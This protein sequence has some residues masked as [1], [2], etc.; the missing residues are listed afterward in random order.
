MRTFSLSYLQ[1]MAD[2]VRRQNL[3]AILIAPS[4]DLLFI[5][6]HNPIFCER[7]QGL[8]VKA[9]GDYFYVCNLLTKEEMEAILPNRKVYAWFDGDGFADT[10]RTALE[11]N[12]LTGKTIGVNATVRA[13][14]LLE[15]SEAVEV[16]WVSAR[17]LPQEIRI[18]KQPSS[19]D[20]LLLVSTGKLFDRCLAV[21]R[22]DLQYVNIFICKFFLFFPAEQMEHTAFCLESDNNILTNRQVCDNTLF[23]TVFRQICHT[24]HHCVQRC[25]HQKLL[26][27]YKELTRIRLIRTVNTSC[28]LGTS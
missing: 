20:Y 12:G 6:G 9:D 1:K 5:T 17:Y 23:F 18:R 7:F 11:E 2:E 27:L 16:H 24:G 8:F 19:K 3:D 21:C 15:I 13:F 14:N 22:L 28:Q 25:S 10:V 26:T 4:E